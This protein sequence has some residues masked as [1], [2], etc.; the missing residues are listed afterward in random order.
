MLPDDGRN[1]SGNVTSL[2]ILVYYLINLLY[3]KFTET[4]I[5]EYFMNSKIQNE[6]F[7]WC[8]HQYICSLG[9]LNNPSSINENTIIKS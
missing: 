4:K 2:N 7:C 8:V 1:I 5:R 9:Y 3:Y 6:E